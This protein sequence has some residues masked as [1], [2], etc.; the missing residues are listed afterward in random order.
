M[1]FVFIWAYTLFLALVWWFFIMAKIHA[2]KFKNFS[3]KIQS[4]TNLVLFTLI[5]LSILWYILIFFFLD[6]FDKNVFKVDYK[7]PINIDTE[8][9]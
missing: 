7:D 8:N 3:D 9:Y 4:I 6:S 1:L 2:Y 5:I